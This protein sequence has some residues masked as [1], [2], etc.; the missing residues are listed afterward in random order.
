MK[1]R[2]RVRSNCRDLAPNAKLDLFLRYADKLSYFGANWRE[3]NTAQLDY[4]LQNEVSSKLG[5]CHDLARNEWDKA[6]Q[7]G[8]KCDE[9]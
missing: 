8:T 2:H 7:S 3:M 1:A 5:N 4:E 9:M 6:G